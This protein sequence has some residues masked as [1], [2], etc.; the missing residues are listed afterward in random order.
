MNI[1]S[2]L[3]T[4]MGHFVLSHLL[5]KEVIASWKA[6]Y[7]QDPLSD[8]PA[9]KEQHTDKIDEKALQAA[10]REHRE[11]R[12]IPRLRGGRILDVNLED[13]DGPGSLARWYR[14]DV[15]EREETREISAIQLQE[16][17][18]EMLGEEG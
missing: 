4:R 10:L 9:H 15:F 8:I 12:D 5:T 1:L 13:L 16:K 7:V 14:R 6:G 3:Q 17:L 11:S 2:K 18:L